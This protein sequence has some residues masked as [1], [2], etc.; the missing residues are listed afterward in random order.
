MIRGN[1]VCALAPGNAEIIA[2]FPGS[3]A[4]GRA[5]VTVNN[6]QITEL[7]ADPLRLEV[8]DTARLPIFGKTACGIHE[9]F[10]Q[11]D[12]KLSAHGRNAAAI[13]LP[14]G[15]SIKGVATG[16]A[17][18]EMTW[19]NNVKEQVAVSVVN[20]PWANLQIRPGR[21]TITKGQAL[22]YE[23]TASKGGLLRVLGPDQGLQLA[24]GDANVA[25]V[26]DDL[27]VG[28]KQEGRTT[29]VARFGALSAEAALNVTAGN[30]VATGVVAGGGVIVQPQG[31]TVTDR[32]ER[33]FQGSTADAQS[34]PDL[35]TIDLKAAHLVVTPDP[36]AIWVGE[37][38]SLGSVKL[39]PGG[40]QPAFPV[41]F[42]ATA[43]DGQTVV[44]LDYDNKIS[45]LV[46]GG[47]QLI[48]TAT[49]PKLQGLATNVAVQVDNPDP[50]RCRPRRHH[51]SGGRN[52]AAGHHQRQG[53]GRHS[54]PG[55][56]HPGKPGREGAGR[57]VRRPGSFRGQGDGADTVEG[58]LQKLGRL[59]HGVTVPGK[60][61][62]E[63]K[64]TP[65]Q[66]D[67]KFDVTVEI[68]ASAA[69]GPLAYRV[70]VDGETA[71]DS[72]TPDEPRGDSRHV[73]L[74]GLKPAYASAGTLYHLV[75]EARDAATKQVQ[76][77]SV[78]LRVRP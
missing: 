1:M 63:V 18:V 68:F 25:Q 71:P 22:K 50:L 77:Y 14:G 72:W 41:N 28:G 24:V 66:G 9:L 49:D 36:L 32:G 59:Y 75:I 56:G 16:E 12:L 17:A 51:A 27:S 78:T 43:P 5:Y 30:A 13:G 74:H 20:T 37:G 76:Q 19:R 52:D 55:S 33:V 35:T 57:R 67:K 39:D 42:Q 11:A 60:R 21:A 3:R 48:V 69:E 47:V 54:L 34:T 46:K 10:P 40:G 38:G 6:E 44:R 23:V 15:A 61:F 26:L 64:T 29:V 70:Y 58:P 45:G 2:T 31:V 8:G 7:I 53:S 65:T 73:I 62:M 4:T